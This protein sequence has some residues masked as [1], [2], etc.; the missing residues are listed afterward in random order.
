MKNKTKQKIK[1]AVQLTLIS[2]LCTGFVLSFHSG[3]K[4]QN[5]ETKQN[6]EIV[7]KIVPDSI[8][9]HVR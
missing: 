4:K 8:K 6:T 1:E 7:N 5:K 3:N 9:Q 2:I